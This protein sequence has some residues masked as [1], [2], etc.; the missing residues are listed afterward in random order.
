MLLLLL[1]CMALV[2]P[3]TGH[4]HFTLWRGK[5]STLDI[6][7]TL[8]VPTLVSC[9][10]KIACLSFLGCMIE[11]EGTKAYDRALVCGWKEEQGLG[12][13]WAGTFILFLLLLAAG[14]R[15]L[16]VLVGAVERVWVLGCFDRWSVF[17]LGVY[18]HDAA[19]EVSW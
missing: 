10:P 4:H 2:P 19:R 17:S 11:L 7:T 3:A 15:S 18:L 13:G 5:I 8:A 6:F 16:E 12:L 14:A 1:V 9:S